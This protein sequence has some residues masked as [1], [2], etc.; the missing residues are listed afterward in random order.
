MAELLAMAE[1][2]KSQGTMGQ[3]TSLDQVDQ[4]I[5]GE[6]LN[7]SSVWDFYD[8]EK[9]E[10]MSKDNN[11]KEKLIINYYDKMVKGMLLIFF[12]IC[13]V[14]VITFINYKSV[15]CIRVCRCSFISNCI[16]YGV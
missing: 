11:E 7:K 1:E 4:K 6:F 14:F 2:P 16:I 9:G 3:V 8:M 10:Y 5:L 13:Y 12:T 15:T